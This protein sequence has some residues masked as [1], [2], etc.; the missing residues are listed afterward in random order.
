VAGTNQHMPRLG[1]VEAP[2][3]PRTLRLAAYTTPAL[4]PPPKTINWYGKVRQWP[5]LGN[6]QIGDCVIVS[7]SHHIQGWSA[8]TGAEVLV[9][10]PD[11]VRAYSAVS[12]YDPATGANDDGCRILDALNLWRATGIGGRTI[13]AYVRVNHQDLA[14]VRAAAYLFGGLI[15]AARLPKAAAAQFRTRR[16]WSVTGGP[17]GRAGSWGG[18]AMH[19]AGADPRGFTVSTWGSTQHLTVG[20]WKTYVAEAYAVI[21]PEWVADTGL[22]PSGLNMA[23]LVA[24]LHAITS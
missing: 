11:V 24:D 14:E 9:A 2:P 5:V 21:G 12:G 23:A 7:C 19:L 20:W 13:G 3:D 1:W 6:D 4:P 17:N 8:Y 22:S 15:I 16:M 10:Q 18:H